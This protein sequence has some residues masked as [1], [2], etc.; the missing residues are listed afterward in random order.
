M[1]KIRDEEAKSLGKCNQGKG[2]GFGPI[3]YNKNKI[4]N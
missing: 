2:G 4:L 3:R 1:P